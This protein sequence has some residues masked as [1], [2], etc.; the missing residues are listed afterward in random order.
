MESCE[1]DRARTEDAQAEADIQLARRLDK[2]KHSTA[3]IS[4]KGGVGKSTVAVNLAVGLAQQGKRVGL[5]DIDVHGPSIPTMLGLQGTRMQ[6]GADGIDPVRC[7]DLLV[8][9]V[10]L[11]LPEDDAPVIWRGPMKSSVIRQ[12]LAEVAWGELDHL[13]IDCPPG[14]GDESLSIC[15]LLGDNT[16]AVIVTTPQEVAAADVRRCINFCHKLDLSITGL[17][18]NMRGFR[19]PDCGSETHIFSQGGG[20]KLSES[21]NIPLIAFIPI[22]PSVC[23]RADQ[24]ITLLETPSNTIISESFN[25]LIKTV[26]EESENMQRHKSETELGNPTE[27]IRF[28]VP[29]AEGVLCNHFGHCETFALLDATAG[30]NTITARQ[31]EVPPPHEPGLLPKWLAEKGVTTVI[32]GGMGMRAQNLFSGHGIKVVTGAPNDTPEILVAN[33]LQGVLETGDNMCDH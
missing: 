18:E 28:A 30:D 1:V 20:Q 19:C 21:H 2:V 27:T 8:A 33:Y 25:Q 22:D 31:D 9:S 17:V 11:M 10:G 14:T 16:G 23:L 3:I 24:G 4:G 6:Q 5:L 15:Q 26:I 12:L 13:I 7:G 29:L 32:A